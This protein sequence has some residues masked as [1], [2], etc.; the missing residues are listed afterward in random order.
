MKRALLLILTSMPLPA[1]A[2]ATKAEICSTVGDMAE[3]VMTHRQSGAKMSDMLKVYGEELV[4][5]PAAVEQISKLTLLAFEQPLF[6][7]EESKREAVI[8]FRNRAEL[9]CYKS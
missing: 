5:V 7:T 3:N 9:G 8:E 1:L 2:E 6:S 4:A